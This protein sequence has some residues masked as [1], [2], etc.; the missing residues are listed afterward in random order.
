MIKLR[1]YKAEPLWMG[2]VSFLKDFERALSLSAPH[3]DM[4][5]QQSVNLESV[6]TG[7]LTILASCSRTSVS[8]PS[9]NKLH[10][11]QSHTTL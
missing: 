1:R 11:S 6:P 8:V 9:E 5:C 3:E 10:L 4:R 2:L 7:G